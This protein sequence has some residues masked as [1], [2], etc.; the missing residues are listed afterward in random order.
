MD[1]KHTSKSS[2]AG[3]GLKINLLKSKKKLK[4]P[5]SSP[6]KKI[7]ISGNNTEDNQPNP[8]PQKDLY[9]FEPPNTNDELK[10]NVHDLI[11]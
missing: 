2:G 4:M 1:S 5:V 7:F 10:D 11:F 8:L 3:V 6:A 9:T